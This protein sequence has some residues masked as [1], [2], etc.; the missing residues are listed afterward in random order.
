MAIK[1]HLVLDYSEQQMYQ[2]NFASPEFTIDFTSAH[3]N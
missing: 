2:T 3:L 1:H